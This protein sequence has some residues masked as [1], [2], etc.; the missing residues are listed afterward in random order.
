MKKYI[1]IVLIILGFS[2]CSEYQKAI[3]SEDLTVK[4][5]QASKQYEK[6]KYFKALTLFEQ[7][8]P[9]FRG[10][11]QAEKMFYMFSQ[12]YYKTKQYY[13]S[14]YQFESFA[15]GFPKSDQVEEASFLGA[16]SYS[17]LSPVYS[18]DQTDTE[19]AIDKFQSF[20][21]AFPN[22]TF[23]PEANTIV[24]GLR[25][26][27]EKKAYENAYGYNKISDF[28]SALIALDNFIIDYPG[29]PY[30]EKALYY[31]LD[32]AYQLAINSIPSKMEERLI[33]AKTAYSNLLKF[34]SN[35]EFK[36]K[37]DDMLERI[38]K[39]LKQFSK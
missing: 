26:K 29:T 37:A 39:D 10:Q 8:A 15:A 16:K 14:G 34:N 9:S 5:D 22:S 11:P 28:K 13:L 33:A 12:S 1:Y 25:E 20:I 21:D 35:T 3:K 18:L 36:Q 7:M 31:K 23:L 17:M 30:K 4:F 38:N 19:K 32:S 6:G 24:K 2:S 27:I